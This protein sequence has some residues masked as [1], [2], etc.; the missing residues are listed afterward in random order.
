MDENNNLTTETTAAVIEE[1]TPVTEETAPA[2]E[3]AVPATE[4]AAPIIE[5]NAPITEEASPITENTAPTTEDTSPITENTSPITENATPIGEI[6][7]PT[8]EP[9][10]QNTEAESVPEAIKP[11]VLKAMKREPAGTAKTVAVCI[12]FGLLAFVFAACSASSLTLRKTFQSS[13][14][15]RAVGE[16]DPSDVRVGNFLIDASMADFLETLYIPADRLKD[17][18]TIAEVVTMT[19]AQYGRVSEA[20]IEELLSDSKVMPELGKL[21]GSYEQYL[22]TGKDDEPLSHKKLLSKI[23]DLQPEIKAYTGIDISEYY[24]DIEESLKGSSKEIRQMNPSETLNGAGKYTA[25]ALSLPAVIILGVL[26]LGMIAI[27]LLITKRPIASVRTMGIIFA[28]VGAALLTVTFLRF[29]IISSADLG[30]SVTN[31]INKLLDSYAV[32]IFLTNGLIFLG[33]GTLII[34]VVGVTD[35]IIKKVRS[36]KIETE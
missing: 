17:D 11:I 19:S 15:S 7:A 13:A 33:A 1:T 6:P 3:E 25:A 12:L 36:S 35:L 14:L 23:K 9:T 5:E 31:Y 34:T 32:P 21:V 22:L 29:P 8:T 20:D 28:T 18:S 30:T 24:T 4:E 2:I 26:S 10:P 16:V 27:A